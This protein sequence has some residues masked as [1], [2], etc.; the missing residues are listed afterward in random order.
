MD[1]R[2]G[3]HRSK[4]ERVMT[5]A[6]KDVQGMTGGWGE[7]GKGKGM[8]LA[9]GAWNWI[10]H[11]RPRAVISSQPHL[12]VP[13]YLSLYAKHFAE[14]YGEVSFEVFFVHPSLPLMRHHH[15]FPIFFRATTPFFFCN[16]SNNW[17]FD[18]P[19]RNFSFLLYVDKI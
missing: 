5:A 6:Y 1:G 19:R 17:C 12:G 14:L 9:D 13:L 8:C 2:G 18:S 4:G 10:N 15:C 7:G 16:N 3:V 11:P